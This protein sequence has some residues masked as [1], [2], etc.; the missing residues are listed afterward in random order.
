MT[1]NSGFATRGVSVTVQSGIS[2]QKEKK[3]A[4]AYYEEKIRAKRILK[5][6]ERGKEGNWKWAFMGGAGRRTGY[7]F[8]PKR[9]RWGGELRLVAK[10]WQKR[11]KTGK[12]ITEAE[13]E[14]RVEGKSKY[15]RVH[16]AD[17]GGDIAMLKSTLGG[18]GVRKGVSH[19]FGGVFYC[20]NGEGKQI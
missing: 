4:G 9:K 15:S 16:G 20:L 8:P 5:E 2:T 11:T 17:E 18:M 10:L 13:N 14:G 6:K 7:F 1:K 12:L 19:R 3:I